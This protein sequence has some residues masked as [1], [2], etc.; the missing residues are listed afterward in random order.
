[1]IKYDAAYYYNLL[2]IHSH[3]AK[4]INELRWDFIRPFIIPQNWPPV[5]LDYGCGVGWFAAYAPVNVIVDTFDIMPIPQTGIQHKKYDMVT[6]WD[7]LEHVDWQNAPDKNIEEIFTKTDYI[8]TTIP[9]LPIG[10]N[11]DS[12][13]HNKPG[14]HL[15]RFQTLDAVIYFFS[16]RGFILEQISIYECPPREDVYSFIFKKELK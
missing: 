7:V 12:W 8:A 2:K 4:Q 3:T 1:M 14:E 13:K 5:I 6:M 11:F 16:L 10:K 15:Y 9:I